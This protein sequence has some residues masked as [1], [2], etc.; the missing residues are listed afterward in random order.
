MNIT[1]T[2]IS[3]EHL[4]PLQKRHLEV[5]QEIAGEFPVI[6]ANLHDHV[7]IIGAFDLWA[8]KEYIVPKRLER[9]SSTLNTTIHETAHAITRADDGTPEHDKA[10]KDISSQ[11]AENARR[12]MYDDYLKDV[13]W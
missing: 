5:A 13:K 8:K 7:V 10:I 2:T 9:L 4:T 11:V 3:E 1:I 6:P 12:G